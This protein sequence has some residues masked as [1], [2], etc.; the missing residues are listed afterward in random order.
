MRKNWLW[1]QLFRY[2]IVKLG[3]HIF[4]KR[5][6]IEGR[7]RLPKNKPILF[8]PNHQNSFMDALL[9]VTHVKQFIYFLTRAQA[10][11]P[12]IMAK[13]LRSLNMLPVY[14]V[15]DGL[16]SV[17]KNKAIFDECISYLKRNDAILIFAE[18]NHDL[19]R[20]VR[21]LSKG[22][23]RL[24]F[25]AEER[26]NWNMGLHVVPVGLNYTE[27][28]RSRN[29]VRVV[30]G[31]PIE[32][33]KYEALFKENE[34]EATRQLK[35]EVAEGMK[36]TVMHVQNLDHYALY[37]VVLTRLEKRASEYLNPNKVN[38]RVK[39]L[40][41]HFDES[42]NQRAEEILDISNQT[43]IPIQAVS[44]RSI[45]WLWLILFAPFYVFSWLNNIVPY[46]L[47]MNFIKSK[48]KDPVFDASIKFV[49]GLVL[50]PIFWVLMS[51][52]LFLLP[53]PGWLAGVYLF[54]SVITSVLFKNANLLR[55]VWSERKKLALLATQAPEK[56]AS[57]VKGIEELNEFREKVLASM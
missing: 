4:Y 35:H 55:E 20:R 15:R 26:E 43:G 28:R 46:T 7:E 53:I 48:V 18:A 3:L 14:R 51:T 27:H 52:M 8:V 34:H 47:G 10:F 31:E 1:Y 24:A 36:K 13:F 23:T 2:P 6:T 22:F 19:R 33:K 40:E 50:F 56:Y 42:L 5:I 49:I 39:L 12:P 25:D 37:D 44:G 45:P 41:Q 29:E 21:P 9:I 16:S 54:L 57:F 30:F 11:N 17:T 32:M 38:A